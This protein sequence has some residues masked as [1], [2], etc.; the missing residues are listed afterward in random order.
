MVVGDG[1]S[2]V[3]AG[4]AIGAIIISRLPEK[5]ARQRQ[6][7]KQLGTNLILTDYT[8]PRFKTMFRAE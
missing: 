5:A 2:E 1:R 7:H 4:V 6:L 3:T 8:S